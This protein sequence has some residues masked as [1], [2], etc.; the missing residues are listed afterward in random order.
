MQNWLEDTF[1]LS[2]L[3]T[4]VRTEVAAGLTT[5]MTMAYILFVQPAVLAA[6][7][8][9]AGAVFVATCV[10]SAVGTLLMG[11]ST[12]YPIAQA[13]AMGHNFYFAF[14]A[15]PLIASRLPENA[16]VAPWQIALGAVFISGVVFL[17]LSYT[18]LISGII[19]AIPQS[20]KNGIAVGIGIMIALVGL[21]WSGIVVAWPATLMR[22]GNLHSPPVLL[23]LFGLVVTLL[24]LAL[25]VRG[26]ILIGIIV[27]AL[28][29][30]PAGL[31]KYQGLLSLPPSLA[32]TFFRL[33]V[34]GAL[35]VGIVTI[36]FTFFILDL[37]DTVGTLVGV[38][39]QAG[40]IKEGKLPHAREALRADAG[41]TVIGAVLG[42]STVTSYIESAAGIATGGRSGLANLVTGLFFL[43]ALFFS[44]LM[45]MIGSPLTYTMMLS[46]GN[47]MELKLYPVV[48]PALIVV[49]S[50][51]MANVS[52]IEWREPTEALP[53]FLTILMI[54]F[55]GF[56]I[57]EGIAFGF[58]SYA[59]LKALSGRWRE[60][61]WLLYLFAILFLWR[62]F[63]LQ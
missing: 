4:T 10:A 13:P 32:P 11:L 39:E 5:F 42:T 49:G 35:D 2:E 56:S 26:A 18:R 34:V 59:L 9:D 63:F 53:A 47:P 62:Y 16:V 40:F 52:K 46:D 41:G 1:R 15:V 8:M 43:L 51:M 38:G 55:S 60:V 28:V 58:I 57:T 20:L 25:E 37:F 29:G 31:V 6:C 14:A 7:G 24:L 36:I 33:D 19:E 48:A 3:G 23:A 12:N 44:P 27:T 30:L 50:F 54:P 45:K 21:Q 61:H 17:V 22:L